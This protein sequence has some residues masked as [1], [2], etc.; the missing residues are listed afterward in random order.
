VPIALIIARLK[1]KAGKNRGPY[2]ADFLYLSFSAMEAVIGAAVE[3][4]MAA[5][6]MA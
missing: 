3:T 2:P 1:Q 4:I 5:A 6:V